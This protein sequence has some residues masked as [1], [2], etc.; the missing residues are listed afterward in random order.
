VLLPCKLFQCGYEDF[1]STS[2]IRDKTLDPQGPPRNSLLED[3]VYYWRRDSPPSF[4][5]AMP[6]LLSISYYSFKIMVAEW[7][8]FANLVH[9]S[10][11]NVECS[12]EDLSK[13]ITELEGLERDLRTLQ[14]W[15]RQVDE[16]TFKIHGLIRT[17]Q[18]LRSD[19][20]FSDSWESIIEDS[21]YVAS[22]IGLY[23]R[24]FE[25]MVPVLT[26]LIQISESRLSF[27]ETKNI[28][29]LTYMAL[30]FVPLTFVSSLFSMSGDLAP[31][32]RHFW[33]YF[34]VAAPLVVTVFMVVRR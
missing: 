28:S 18:S 15:R 25:A 20:S 26:G 9:Y 21:S 12:F 19:P 6:S 1:S 8:N 4:N 32:K 14:R 27:A 5:A 24:R 11:E 13:N 29:R 33:I 22:R 3:L 30:V 31:G 34:L 23:G 17:V 7:M 10:V 16:A 2:V